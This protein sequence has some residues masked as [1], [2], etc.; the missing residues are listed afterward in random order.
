MSQIR[1]TPVAGDIG[2]FGSER[3]AKYADCQALIL[4]QNWLGPECLPKENAVAYVGREES[5]ITFYVRME[6]SQ[7]YTEARKDD[8]KMWSLGDTVEF[9]VKPGLDRDDYWELHVAPNDLIMDLHIADRDAFT[10]GELTWEEVVAADSGSRQARRGSRRLVDRGAQSAVDGIWSGGGAGRRDGLAVRSLPLQLPGQAGGSRAF[11]DSGFDRGRVSSPRGILRTS[12]LDE[13]LWERGIAGSWPGYW[14]HRPSTSSAGMPCISL[15]WPARYTCS[16][17]ARAKALTTLQVTMG[18][19]ILLSAIFQNDEFAS[20][21]RRRGIEELGKLGDVEF[22]DQMTMMAEDGK[23]VVAII[24]GSSLFTPEFYAAADDLLIIARWG[25]GFDQVN[26]DVATERGVLVTVTPVHMV[27][28]AEYAIAQWMAT[29]K[30]TY[31]LNNMSHGGDFSLIRTYEIEGSTL[32]LYGF[33]RIGQAVAERAR[34]LLGD[35]GRLLVYDIRPDIAEVAATFGAE[36]VD[37]PLILFR[38]CDTVSL[39]VAGDVTIVGY[40]QLC[41]MQ[42]HASLINPSRGNLVDDDAVNR[43]I[44]ENRLCF[45]V[46]DDPVNGPRAIHKDNP[47]IICT[48]H[49]GGI[50]VESCAR[51]DL[52]TFDQVTA[53]IEGRRPDHVLNE[54]VLEHPRVKGFLN[55]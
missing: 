42:P 48:N 6:D 41:A 55:L 13:A 12:F 35:T 4:R 5:A 44:D 51:L 46:V 7:I 26:V 43:A 18:K 27:T 21:P 15:P 32:G 28:V 29:M 23:D 9:F 39:H 11:F 8:D 36:A 31:M 24:A 10:R 45:Y 40:E 47:R 22:Y 53:A 3:S 20:E 30:R 37:D 54:E 17:A 52:T 38:E 14:Q 33:G 50:T 25:V 34:S 2:D 49:N 1:C 19:R 16:L